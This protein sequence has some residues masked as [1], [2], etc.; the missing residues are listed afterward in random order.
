MTAPA[1]PHVYDPAANERHLDDN[2]YDHDRDEE[3]LFNEAAA[4]AVLP[5][6]RGNVD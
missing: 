4:R 2:Y 1:G 5:Q 6:T 3:G